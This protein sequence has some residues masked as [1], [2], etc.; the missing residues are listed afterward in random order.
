[1]GWSSKE[2]VK[3][4]AL[5]TVFFPTTLKQKIFFVGVLNAETM[6]SGSHQC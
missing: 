1:M 4:T 2:K 6:P 5:F 3:F